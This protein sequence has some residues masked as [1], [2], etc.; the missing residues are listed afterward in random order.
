MPH[1]VPISTLPSTNIRKGV[2]T[3]FPSTLPSPAVDYYRSLILVGTYDSSLY[4]LSQSTGQ[5]LDKIDCGG[6]IYATPVISSTSCEGMSK[7]GEGNGGRVQSSEC[8]SSLVYV[9]TT[10]GKLAVLSYTGVHEDTSLLVTP[11][12]SSGSSASGAGSSSKDSVMSVVWSY[13]TSAPIFATPLVTSTAIVVVS[14][15]N[16]DVGVN[17]CVGVGVGY[18]GW[19]RDLVIIGVVDGTIRCL[20]V[21]STILLGGRVDRFHGL[22]GIS[23]SG[24]ELWKVSFA[25]K[26]IFSS[27]CCVQGNNTVSVYY[28]TA[29]DSHH[30]TAIHDIYGRSKGFSSR[31]KIPTTVIPILENQKQCPESSQ[32]LTPQDCVVVFGAHDGVLRAVSPGG[33]L[34]WQTDLGSVI[35]SSPCTIYNRIVIGATTAGTVYA[36]DCRGCSILAVQHDH[37][38]G[39]SNTENRNS[40]ADSSVVSLTGSSEQKGRSI[41]QCGKILI[42]TRLSG[43]VYSSPVVRDGCIFLGCRDDKVHR[44]TLSIHPHTSP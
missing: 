17:G 23:C 36:V 16:V 18:N 31:S 35:F 28:Q 32:F 40:K 26:P 27:P 20:A 22:P 13:H 9:A 29:R 6:S 8:V 37:D 38:G 39:V 30:T 43:E 25:S 12:A 11:T 1:F 34:L 33:L 19:R 2:V 44:I 41:P 10:Q 4:V 7:E 5:V 21:T 15:D 3:L 42:S 24:E 14:S